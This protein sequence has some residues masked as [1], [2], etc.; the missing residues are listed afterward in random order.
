M[1]R[2]VFTSNR[3]IQ[4]SSSTSSSIDLLDEKSLSNGLNYSLDTEQ[5]CKKKNSS[6][7]IKKLKDEKITRTQQD[8]QDYLSIKSSLI[9]SKKK[10]TKKLNIKFRQTPNDK[11]KRRTYEHF[12]CAVIL[13]DCNKMA[14]LLKDNP[15][16]NLSHD[17]RPDANTLLHTAVRYQ[18]K[19]ALSWLASRCNRYQINQQNIV[20]DSPLHWAV[21]ERSPILVNILLNHKACNH[22]QNYLNKETPLIL[23]LNLYIKYRNLKDY[24]CVHSNLE[25]NSLEHNASFSKL[26]YKTEQQSINSCFGEKK[27]EKS[28]DPLQL[29]SN[30]L[31]KINTTK[32]NLEHQKEND[33]NNLNRL[34]SQSTVL[35][36]HH[37]NQFD[38]LTA[39][40][41]N[42]QNCCS[43]SEF[44]TTTNQLPYRLDSK[45]E[46]ETINNCRLMRKIVMAI[47]HHSDSRSW[48]LA[49]SKGQTV[50]SIAKQNHVD[51]VYDFICN[52]EKLTM[53][54]KPEQLNAD[55]N[56]NYL[57]T[58]AFQQ[59]PNLTNEI[60]RPYFKQQDAHLL[61]TTLNT[62]ADQTANQTSINRITN[63]DRAILFN[64]KAN[65][66][67][68]KVNVEENKFE[69]ALNEETKIERTS[70]ESKIET[71]SNKPYSIRT[72]N[73]ASFFLSSS[74]YSNNNEAYIGISKKMNHHKRKTDEQY[75]SKEQ[76]S[77]I[78]QDNRSTIRN[79]AIIVAN[80]INRKS[81]RSRS[82][83]LG[84]INLLEK[85]HNLFTNSVQACSSLNRLS[86]LENR[87]ETFNNLDHFER[88]KS[89]KFNHQQ[90]SLD[91]LDV[92]V[93]YTNIPNEFATKQ[94]IIQFSKPDSIT[95]EQQNSMNQANVKTGLVSCL[96]IRMF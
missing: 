54:V 30:N 51:F 36:D 82:I 66:D 59:Q 27:N 75:C 81:N 86:E 74:S 4:R 14:N 31:K 96:S 16:L 49:N 25:L 89:Q 20:G 21:R 78:K 55:Q 8:E 5:L 77:M 52:Y 88:Q 33:S 23:A 63:E 71:N 65:L 43:D 39:V 61:N 92:P 94:S 83:T 53:T 22:V 40:F 69:N 1:W 10:L 3:R 47:L 12:E 67:E 57:V 42:R 32:F 84:N 29:E 2:T 64:N 70:R 15:K 13:N 85:N 19:D 44:R 11:I 9:E 93:T 79:A 58:D 80:S 62:T 46:N 34:I 56:G 91:L 72:R 38:N 37:Q 90:N 87:E 73:K 7:R 68:V 18:C 76:R 45:F 50:F 24:A 41:L 95:E 48:Q 6:L 28:F 17:L 60:L 35:Y 26:N